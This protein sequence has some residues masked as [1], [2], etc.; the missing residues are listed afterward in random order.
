MAAAQE[1]S[2]ISFVLHGAYQIA[3]DNH[4]VDPPD[5]FVIA[6][7]LATMGQDCVFCSEEFR[8][9]EQVTKSRMG[10]VGLWSVEDNF[11]ITRQ[12]DLAGARGIVG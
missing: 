11:R 8:F 12:L 5:G 1:P 10:R 3:F 4:H 7:A 6:R 9:D 2:A